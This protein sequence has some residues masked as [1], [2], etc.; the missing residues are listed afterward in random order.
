MV[1]ELRGRRAYK[2][3]MNSSPLSHGHR[4]IQEGNSYLETKRHS[5]EYGT[6]ERDGKSAE[7]TFFLLALDFSL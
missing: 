4:P 5:S 1:C 7:R 2:G 6:V 3:S